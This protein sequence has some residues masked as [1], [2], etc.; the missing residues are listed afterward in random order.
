MLF[1]TFPWRRVAVFVCGFLWIVGGADVLHATEAAGVQSIAFTANAGQWPDSILFRAE[2]DGMVLWFTRSAVYH[3]VFHDVAAES[4]AAEGTTAEV[5]ERVETA[6][7]GAVFEDV[8]PAVRV[9]PGEE[10][11]YRSSYFLGNDPT[12]WRSDVPNYA[13]IV[14]RDLYP[15]VDLVFDGAG[16]ALRYRF[17][18]ASEAAVARVSVRYTGAAGLVRRDGRMLAE[19]RWGTLVPVVSAIPLASRD[20]RDAGTTGDALHAAASPVTLDYSTYVAGSQEDVA[21]DIAVDGNSAAYVVGQT[22]SVDFPVV[23]G[24]DLSF[25]G[26]SDVFVLKLS[27]DGSVIQ[28]STYV[29]GSNTDVGRS[30]YL[31]LYGNVYVSGD[32]YVAGHT[33]STD[34]PEVNAYGSG[35]NGLTDWFVLRL[36]PDLDVL[37]YSTYF[38][39]SSH[40]YPRGLHV[41][42]VGTSA[43]VTV[44]G[45]TQSS[46]MPTMQA[47]QSAYGGG[48]GDGFI[49][50]FDFTGGVISLVYATYLGGGAGDV[51]QDVAVDA[52]G[53]MYVTGHTYSGNFPLASPF[54]ATLGGGRDAFISKLDDQGS[55]LYSTYLGGG[56]DEQGWGIV[57]DAGGNI[58]A[59]GH[60]TSSDFPTTSGAFDQTYAGGWDTYVVMFSPDGQMQQYGT[61]LGGM[62]NDWNEGRL[63]VN[64]AGAACV[65]GYT[66]SDDFPIQNPFSGTRAGQRDVYVAKVSPLGDALRFGTYIGGTGNDYGYGIAIDPSGAVYVVGQTLSGDFPLENPAVPF[67]GGGGDVFALRLYPSCCY[68]ITGNINCD[69]GDIVDI[70]DLT[71]LIDHL[72]IS[73]AP[74]CCPEEGNV[75]G[76]PGNIVDIADLTALID[77][78]FI[79]FAPTAPCQ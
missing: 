12:R 52:A 45:Y 69:P 33:S 41:M 7:I 54:D 51:I 31:D 57:V 4:A 25:G 72:F 62:A 44:A 53:N 48:T 22:R 60:T 5:A 56:F 29:G 63:A 66:L 47:F 64:A 35:N 70:A 76:D 30:I 27:P 61:L 11:G 37:E 3:Q 13:G 17:E 43:L 26:V 77:H 28:H 20:H 50:R 55:L 15:G 68:G 1:P 59:S 32:V 14:Y 71:A 9:E 67:Y 38:G 49:A 46:N 75:N 40:E 42:T 23:N 39:G 74:L 18:S 21:W 10:L 34:F 2:A 6:L 16:G 8:G 79:N 36:S 58:Y 73:F 19:T 65:A 24:Y 78:L